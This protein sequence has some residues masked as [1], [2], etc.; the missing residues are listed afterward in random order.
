MARVTFP[1]DCAWSLKDVLNAVS[2]EQGGEGVGVGIDVLGAQ[3]GLFIEHGE[4]KVQYDG[5]V[6]A[7]SRMEFLVEQIQAVVSSKDKVMEISLVTA[8][9]ATLPD[10]AAD[11]GWC[12]WQGAITNV[13]KSVSGE[14]VCVVDYSGEEVKEYSYSAIDRAA[15]VLARR[16]KG[17]EKD[18]VVMV[19]AFRG[20]EMLVCALGILM[21]GGVSRRPCLVLSLTFL[22][23]CAL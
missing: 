7:R 22:R 6:F 17:I 23:S 3:T 2:L 4:V 9:Q 15:K 1:S 21:T 8:S 13:F 14:R 10:P 5:R 11:L 19:Y 16:L 12:A 20:V 18:D